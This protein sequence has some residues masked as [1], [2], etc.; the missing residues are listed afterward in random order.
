MSCIL[1]LAFSLSV[2]IRRS[3][4]E[5]LAALAV[6]S[7]ARDDGSDL[8]RLAKQTRLARQGDESLNGIFKEQA[9]TSRVPMGN[10]ELDVLLA[11]CKAASAVNDLEHASQLAAQ[12]SRYLPECPSQLFRSSPFLQSVKPSPWETLSQ[13]LTTALLSL[14]TKY[15]S[16][17]KIVLGAVNGYLHNCSEAINAATPFQYSTSEAGGRG[18]VQESIAILSIA[19]SLVGFLE[20]SAKYTVIWTADEKLRMIDHLRAMLSESFMIA[21]ETASSTIRNAGVADNTLKDWRKYTRRYAAHG[22]PL[23]AMLVQEGFMRFVKSS[24]ASLIGSQNLSDDQLLDEYMAGVG[25]AKSNDEADI[26]LLERITNLIS[27]EIRL[28]E[29][30]SD[31]LQV[32]SPSQQR[33]AFS[34]KGEALVGF[35]NCVVLGEDA[36][37]ND[38]LLSWLEDTLGDP[39]QMSSS[40]LAITALKCSAILARLSSEGASLGRRCLLKFLS[41]GGISKSSV[42]IVASRCLA[43]VLSIL[44][45]DSVIATLYSLGNTLSPS[46]NTNQMP[47]DQPM[48]DSAGTANNL[49]SF[50]QNGNASQPSFSAISEEGATTHRNVIH[51]IVTI[52]TSCNDDKI[53]ALAQS[54]LLQKVGKI[55]VAV[56]AYI[57]QE[58]AVL[59]L[60]SGQAEFQLL[61]KFYTR[62][63]LDGIRKGIDVI[64]DA[65][66]CAM[67]Y[68][69]V[70]LSRHSPLHRLY[71]THLLESIVNKGDVPD[72]ETERHREVVFAPSDITPLLKPLALLVSSKNSSADTSLPSTSYDD[73]TLSLFRDAWFN[74]AIHGISLTSTAAQRHLKELCLLASHSPPLVAEDRMESLE[75]DVE[76]NTVLRRGTGP[77]RVL[78]QKRTLIAELPGRESD[79]KRLDYP[80]SVFLNAVLLVESLRASSGDCTKVLSYFRDPAVAAP[81]MVICMNSVAEKVVTCYLSRTLSGD[82]DEFSAPYLSKQLAEF[83][84]ACCHRIERIQNIAAQCTDKI[85]RECPSA[86]CEKHSLFA[87]LEILTVMWSSCLQGELDEFEWKPTLVSPMGIVKVDLP[88]NYAL[89]KATLNR[90]LERARVWVTAVLNV[91]PLDIKGLL[92][93]YLSE[94][95]DDG[96]YGHIAMGRSFALEMGSLI[97]HSDPRLGSIDSHESGV[98][99]ASDFMALYTTRQKYR[100][101]DISLLDTPDGQVIGIDS[102]NPEAEFSQ[103]S[104]TNL[105][106]S[107]ARLYGRSMK[108]DEIPLVEVRDALRQA[109]SLICSSSKP[110]LSVVHYLVALPFQIFTKETIKLGVSLWLGVIHENPGVEPRILAHVVEAWERSIQR[111]QGLFDPSFEYLDPLQ[112][113]IELLPTDKALMLQGQQKAQNT[114]SPH[115]RILQF[116]ESHFSAIRLGN[117]QDQQLFCRLISSTLVA[118]SKTRGHPLAREIHFRIV[119]FGLRILKHLSPRNA[120]A[121]WKLKDQILSAALSWFKH[122]PRW[123]FGGNRLQIKAEDKILGDVLSTLR[124]VADIAAQ[125]QGSF[126]SLQ[127]KQ[128]LVQILIENERSRLRVW[129]FPLEPERKHHMP[130]LGGKNPTEGIAS[131]LR[132]AWAESPGLA[133]QLAA[134]FP[135]AKMQTDIRWL[136]LNFPEKALQEPSALDIMFESS[137]PSDVNFQLKYLLFWAPVNPTEAL[138]YFLPAYGNHPFILQYAM[139]ALESHSIDVRF[140]FVPQLVQALRYDALGY[141]ERYIL[142]TAKLSQLFAHQVIWNMKANSY[143][144][145]DSQVPD[146]IKPTLDRFVETL[147]SSFS[148]EERDFY[149][150]EF[151]FFNEITGVSGK[152]RPYIKRS[153][154]EKKEKIEEELRKIKV[155]VGVYLPSNPDGVVVGIDRKSGK[156]LQSHAKAPYMATF[157][158]Q[159]TRPRSDEKIDSAKPK[160]RGSD[161][162]QLVAHSSVPEL[163]TYEVWQSAIFKVGDDCRQDMLALQMIAAFRSIFSSVGLDVWVFPYRVTSTAPGCGVIDVLPNSISRDML[164]REAVNGLYDYFVSKYGGEDSIRFQ[165]ARTNFVKSMAAYSVISYLLQ[166]KDRHNGN[167]MV[168]D[169]GHIIH[170]DFGFC[171][172]IA[173]GGVRFERAPFKLTSEMV[174]VMSGTHNPTHHPNGTSG[175]SLP[176]TNSH[177]PTTT[178]PYRW[179]ESLVVK[180]FLASRPYCTKL[181]HIVSLMLDSGLP[182]FK[183][184]TLKNFRDRFVLEKTERDAAEYMRDLV[185]KSYMSVSTKGYDQF[186]LM[187]NGIPY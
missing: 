94:Y 96:G 155:E 70:T 5:K 154:P 103:E 47:Q 82:Y 95:D 21:V 178:Q 25:I 145:E 143:K 24:A 123:S 68:I 129:L 109:A 84:V 177:N 185:R 160:A 85:I 50:A 170:I 14:A 58:T 174:A 33:L 133:I 144:D 173:P 60:S 184:E 122:T 34:V 172:D 75:S 130:S 124:T 167:I 164:G 166:F 41:Q 138:T 86:L 161:Q 156:P 32:G 36:A 99:I 104:A 10:R 57:I 16:L 175:I 142:E 27:E 186:Q 15:S 54:M 182:C 114:L 38:V 181:A 46:S 169:A 147:I 74:I 19:V 39:Q 179:F 83:L 40:Q 105:E 67:A 107:L 106:Y 63:Y 20:A 45:E 113:K 141:V 97:P 87:L 6:N 180:A 157:R 140:Y 56:D 52:A 17:R 89:R 149:E 146:P 71:L 23:G 29:D 4:F 162:R 135:S 44:S 77:Q 98:N 42:I 102:R 139:R 117:L 136:I 128:D 176:G 101:P 3:A 80:R 137:L 59:A 134:R 22:R 8:A 168:D 150:R 111:R 100:R 76:L 112:T 18:V 79:I 1:T 159:K 53:S 126:K 171:F 78:E 131:F 72:L 61:L 64:A 165:E 110:R 35:L 116:F 132:L 127:S 90:F 28:L 153:K 119:L 120:A 158:I 163:E 69:S 151:S 13:S 125:T 62:V 2:G 88:D 93:T 51:A 187:T 108:G 7:P 121:S 152:L 9:P 183:P 37:N 26:A 11:L 30:G 12:L 91:A 65:V 66:Q 148:N 49:A 43:Q 31:Y 115:L 118:L 81:E 48:G 92:Q 55:N 73:A